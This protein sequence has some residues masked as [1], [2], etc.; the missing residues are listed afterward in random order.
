[1][2]ACLLALVQ[3]IR[4][5]GKKNGASIKMTKG[6]DSKSVLVYN[7]ETNTSIIIGVVNISGNYVT[8]SYIVDVDKWDEALKNGLTKK[9]I[10]DDSSISS[11]IFTEIELDNILESLL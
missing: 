1:M 6:E 10:M 11:K 2:H 7:E 4:R 3:K 8:V 9:D 5:D